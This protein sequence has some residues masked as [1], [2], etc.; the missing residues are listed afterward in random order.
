MPGQDRYREREEGGGAGR[1]L[2][3]HP[4]IRT[5]HMGSLQS[6]DPPASLQSEYKVTASALTHYK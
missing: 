1:V 6:A 2:Q 4:D 3:L 5:L